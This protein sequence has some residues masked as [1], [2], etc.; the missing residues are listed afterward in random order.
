MKPLAKTLAL[1]ALLLASVANVYADVYGSIGGV[2]RDHNGSPL[3]GVTVTI[4]GALLPKGRDV[5]TDSGGNYSFQTLQPGTYTVTA[6]LAGLGNARGTATVVV[7]KN[8]ALDLKLSPTVSETISVTAA[9]PLVDMKSTEV[10]FNY[11]AK[12]IERLPLPRT[13]QGLFQLAPG[14][15]ENNSFSPVAGGGRQENYFLLDGVKVTNPLFG[16]PSLLTTDANELDIQDF[17]VKR[18]AFSAES[19]RANGMVLNAVTKS[20]TNQLAGAVREEWIPGSWAAKSK[21]PNF[22]ANT[23]RSRTAANIGGPIW[24]DHVFGYASGRYEHTS[25]TSRKNFFGPIPDQI[26]TVKEVFGKLTATPTASQ[27][28]AAGYRHIPVNQPLEGIYTY[29]LPERA[30]DYN[31]TNNVATIDYNWSATNSTLLEGK[32]LRMGEASHYKA[33]TDLGFKPTFN[34][35]DLRHMGAVTIPDPGGSGILVAAG[36]DYVRRSTQ[37]YKHS[38]AKLSVTQ[39]FDF[40]GTNHQVKAGGS[41]EYGEEHMIRLSNGWGRISDIGNNRLRARYYPDQPPL[42]SFGKTY[43]AYVQDSITFNPRL[44]VNVGLL[45]NRDSYGQEKGDL[46]TTF[47]TF[48]MGKQIQPRVGVN[49]NLRA[50]TG[51]KLY[52]NYARYSNMEQKNTAR[53][54][55]PLGLIQ[56]RATFNATTGALISDRVSTAD[57]GA[58]E[59]LPGTKPTYTD[60]Y[61]AG[62]ATPLGSLWSIDTFGM[63]R[64]T[65]HFIEDFPLTMPDDDFVAGNLVN[66]VR[67]YYGVT[68]AVSRRLANRWSA[69]INY[70]WSRLYGNAEWDYSGGGIYTTASYLQDGPGRMV[71]D[72]NRWGA[73]VQNRTHVLKAFATYEVIPNLNLGGYFRYQSGAPWQSMGRDHPCGC[74]GKYLEPAGSH[75]TPSWANFDLSASYGLPLFGRSRVS[76][77]ARV[78]NALNKQTVLSVDT[79]PF[80][81]PPIYLDNAPWITQNFNQPNPNFAKATSYASPRRYIASLRVDF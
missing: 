65:K 3:P 66:A 16:Y 31:G 11:D 43:S 25:S 27:F 45:A 35:N 55:G 46:K 72:P 57:T 50:N 23:T 71:E 80:L 53:G 19:G 9:A 75:R 67:R 59:V 79:V 13:Y 56:A 10:N 37:D 6:S 63:Y 4:A 17:N 21:D 76:F 7:D 54:L 42:L 12:T 28:I 29:T 44:N 5:V 58:A 20:G 73:L 47:L 69:D 26:T 15:A 24:R 68:F 39:F 22:K 41:Y 34:P 52:V 32:L 48:G 78:L 64:D 60:E 81:D 49:Y 77:E 14:V 36:G 51:D 38:Q 8:T 40:H 1:A 61:L 18:G 62:Y 30:Y 2:V 70:T 74:F 33:R